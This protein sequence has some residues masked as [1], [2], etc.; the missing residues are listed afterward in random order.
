MAPLRQGDRKLLVCWT[1][2]SPSGRQFVLMG[3]M[4]MW[5]RRKDESRRMMVNRKC[6]R[7]ESTDDQERK[8]KTEVGKQRPG[9]ATAGS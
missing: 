3:K 7:L 8:K 9:W 6:A 2:A 5:R 1:A 4:E